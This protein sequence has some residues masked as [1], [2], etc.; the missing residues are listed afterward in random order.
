MKLMKK[1]DQSVK[2]SELLRRGTKILTEE[3]G[4][5]SMDQRL[6]ERSFRDCPKWRSITYAQTNPRNYCGYQEVLAD[7][8]LI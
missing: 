5:Q 2:V 6:K 1:E 7:R 4:R 3:I 8:S